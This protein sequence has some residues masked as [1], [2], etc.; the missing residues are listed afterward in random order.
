MWVKNKTTLIE[1]NAL[2]HILIQQKNFINFKNMQQVL[3]VTQ[4]EKMEMSEKW[5]Y[6]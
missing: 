6:C 1:I 5:I 3:I 2:L 4:R